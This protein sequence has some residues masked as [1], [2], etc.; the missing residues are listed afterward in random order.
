MGTL[1]MC[2]SIL[3]IFWHLE[4]CMWRG[5]VVRIII[6][7]VKILV[8]SV[9]WLSRI[10]MHD[11]ACT[12]SALVPPPWSDNQAIATHANPIFGLRLPSMVAPSIQ[13]TPRV[14]T[15]VKFIKGA[16]KRTK[17]YPG[18]FLHNLDRQPPSQV[19]GISLMQRCRPPSTPPLHLRWWW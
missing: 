5:I 4:I 7:V 1:A 11:S 19:V 9:V 10:M 6:V 2:S 13:Y 15:T 14:D 3:S 8:V 12:G 18:S 16:E 17:L